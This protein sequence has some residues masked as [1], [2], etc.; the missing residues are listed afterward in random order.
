MPGESHGQR[1][2]VYYSLWGRK[3]SDMTEATEHARKFQV[4]FHQIYCCKQAWLSSCTQDLALGSSVDTFHESLL[5]DEWDNILMVGPAN[6]LF[7]SGDKGSQEVER[8]MWAGL[9]VCVLHWWHY[10]WVI[11]YLEY[12]SFHEQT[13]IS[14]IFMLLQTLLYRFLKN[15]TLNAVW[16]MAGQS[17]SYAG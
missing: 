17:I 5:Q 3:E 6:T 14:N 8:C 9:S 4:K 16:L 1:N 7:W 13:F 11:T 12:H 15:D 2:L 10:S